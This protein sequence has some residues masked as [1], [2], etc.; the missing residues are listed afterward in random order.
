[1]QSILVF[2]TSLFFVVFAVP[3]IIDIA[4]K[5]HLFDD[6]VESRKVHKNVIPNFGGIALFFAVLFTCTLFIPPATV[7]EANTIIAAGLILFLTGLKDDI[8]VLGP[9]VK[10]MAQLLSAMVLIVAGGF[11]IDNLQGILGIYE[12]PQ[13]ASL[14]LS[15][16][17]IVGVVNAFN[18][19]DGIDG[20][21]GTLASIAMFMF[22]FLFYETAEPGWSWLALS[23]AGALLG[24]LYY[25]FTPAKIFMGDS[26]SLFIGLLAAVFSIKFMN[27]TYV[28]DAGHASFAITSKVSLLS[29]ILVVP[30]FDT[31]R[32][33]TLRIMKGTSPFSADNNHLHH[34]LLSL[35][36]NHIQATAILSGF[37]LLLIIMACSFQRL[38]DNL[39]LTILIITT[40]IG[41]EVLSF[42][43]GRYR[44]ILAKNMQ[45]KDPVFGVYEEASSH[46][47]QKLLQ[48]ISEI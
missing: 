20:L 3:Q 21:A 22:A 2:F 19:I 29:A 12:I 42:L 14:L 45:A 1:M 4:F 28:P 23:V 34:R 44:K 16:L 37:N 11:R 5:K 17:F 39:I 18:L 8:L 24:F 25:N 46:N 30:I 35:A 13:A 6:P 31:L 47:G 9:L 26:G 41:N 36:L 32:V 43:S 40:L 10:F 7:P 15:L 48:K 27:S 33:F 38:G